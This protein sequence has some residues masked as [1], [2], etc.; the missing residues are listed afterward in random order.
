MS[1]TV[2]KPGLL[3][4]LQDGGRPGHAARGVGR[5]GCMDWPAWLLGN[6]LVGNRADEAVLECTLLGPTLRFERPAVVALTGAPVAA[7]THDL[8]L[9]P[10]T[11][12]HLPAGS[13]LAL[14]GMARGCRSYLAVRGGFAADP[15]L[16]S[17]SEDLHAAIG[18]LGGRPLQQGD[19]LHIGDAP[20]LPGLPSGEAA[21]ALRWGVDPRPWFDVH[22]RP[23]ALLQGRHT[24]LLDE[25]SLAH[26]AAGGFVVGTASNRTGY[27]LDGPRL[28]L[29]QP[30]ELVSEPTLPGTMQLPPSGQPIV[31]MAEA[32]VTGG[33]PHIGQVA[34]IDLARLSQRRPGD[35]VNFEPV[36][37]DEARARQASRQRAVRHLARSV[38]QRLEHP[39]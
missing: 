38:L 17:R 28:A 4:S 1:A 36:S 33:Y 11:A 34:A 29:R 3:T 10:W 22:D 26:L 39:S 19:H 15:V 25:P 8:V 37:L 9:P 30:L 2:L 5:S 21:T 13:V 6:A 27:R 18:P 35:T 31:L 14:A 24:H 12:C 20:P 23:V 7:R 16:G 32:P